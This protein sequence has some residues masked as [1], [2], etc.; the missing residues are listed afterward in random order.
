MALLV[1]YEDLLNISAEFYDLFNPEID[2]AEHYNLRI[3]LAKY[4]AHATYSHDVAHNE[5][6]LTFENWAKKYKIVSDKI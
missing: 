6:G 2:T 3:E 4:V 1:K 5:C